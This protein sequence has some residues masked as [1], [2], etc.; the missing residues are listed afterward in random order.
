[1]YQSDRLNSRMRA[2]VEPKRPGSGCQAAPNIGVSRPTVYRWRSRGTELD[3]P[4]SAAPVPRRTSADREAI[5]RTDIDQRNGE[6]AGVDLEVE[7]GRGEAGLICMGVRHGR[8]KDQRALLIDIGG[9]STEIASAV[10]F[11]PA[12]M[13]PVYSSIALGF[14]RAIS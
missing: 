14:S 12:T 4:S 8:P 9:G 11:F 2:F 1:L 10:G 5:S 3:D 7:R 13:L 6:E